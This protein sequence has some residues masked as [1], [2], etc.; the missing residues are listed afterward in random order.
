MPHRIA[1]PFFKST[2]KKSIT[3]VWSS[4]V[5]NYKPLSKHENRVNKTTFQATSLSQLGVKV[6]SRLLT[7]RYAMYR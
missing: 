7:L 2:E 4:S 6:P 1:K 3:A 5:R